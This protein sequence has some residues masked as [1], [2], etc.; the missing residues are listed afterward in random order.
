MESKAGIGDSPLRAS[1]YKY[2]KHSRAPHMNLLSQRGVL[3]I[4]VRLVKRLRPG[5]DH[6]SGTATCALTEKDRNFLTSDI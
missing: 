1:M 5:Y 4:L 6:N 3:D 2:G